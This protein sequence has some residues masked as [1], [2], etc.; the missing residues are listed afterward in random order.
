MR[1]IA[2]MSVLFT[3]IAAHVPAQ[4]LVELDDPIVIVPADDLENQLFQA[5]SL[6]IDMDAELADLRAQ[7]GAGVFEA[8]AARNASIADHERYTMDLRA[9]ALSLLNWQL[10][11]SYV[12]LG[13]VVAVT[14]LGVVLSF[15]EVKNAMKAPEKVMEALSTGTLNEAPADPPADGTPPPPSGSTSLIIS[16]QKLQVT[17]A[18][19]GVVILVLSLGFLYLFV[20]EVLEAVPLDFTSGLE[21]VEDAGAAFSDN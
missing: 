18:I 17:S 7:R 3:L 20:K 21:V 13:L 9:H 11:S 10:V 8:T 12:V 14:L 4:S 15:M 19:T 2:L 1:L 16:A 5:E 6:L